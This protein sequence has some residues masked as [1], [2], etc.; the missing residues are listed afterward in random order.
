[1]LG[2]DGSHLNSFAPMEDPGVTKIRK[3]CHYV[4][5]IDSWRSG[6]LKKEKTGSSFEVSKDLRVFGEI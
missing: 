5:S 3:G 4:T 2:F 1:V 6:L